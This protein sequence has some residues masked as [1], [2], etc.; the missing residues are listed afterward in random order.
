M[1]LDETGATDQ[2]SAQ[3]PIG[4]VARKAMSTY[5]IMMATFMIHDVAS[6]YGNPGEATRGVQIFA[7][8]GRPKAFKAW[9]QLPDVAGNNNTYG[10]A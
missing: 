4:P 5:C 10:R 9:L 8:A 1:G 6:S 2:W 7:A 3:L